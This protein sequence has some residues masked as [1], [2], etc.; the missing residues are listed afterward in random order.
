MDARQSP[1]VEAFTVRPPDEAPLASLRNASLAPRFHA[2]LGAS[3]RRYVTS[4]YPIDL[5]RPLAGLPDFDAFVLIPV[6]RQGAAR[7]PSTI[8][9]VERESDK[10]FAVSAALANDVREWHVHL[11]AERR[12]ERASVVADLAA[13]HDQS[14]LALSA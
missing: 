10:R 14:S 7:R 3:G 8:L 6:V 5:S 9:A 11:L 1:A 12:S 2:W 13:R 4:V